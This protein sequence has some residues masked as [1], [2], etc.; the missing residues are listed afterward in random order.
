MSSPTRLLTAPQV[1]ERLAVPV[2]SV[3]RLG[4]EGA[5]P[6]TR[7]GRLMRFDPALVEDFIAGSTHRMVAGGRPPAAA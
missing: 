6:V 4:R 7:V 5:L 3:W 1:A 2:A